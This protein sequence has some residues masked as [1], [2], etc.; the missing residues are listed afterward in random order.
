[1]RGRRL[2]TAQGGHGR[3]RETVA[4]AHGRRLAMM[5]GLLAWLVAF[6]AWSS[7][8]HADAVRN[9][10]APREGLERAAGDLAG[11]I[12]VSAAE[13]GT[14]RVLRELTD[15]LREI[16]AMPSMDGDMP[17]DEPAAMPREERVVRIGVLAFRGNQRA[18]HRWQPLADYLSARVPGVTFTLQ[19]VTLFSARGLLETGR[20]DYLI[21]N[22]GHYVALTRDVPL[23][24][25]A[26]LER[27]IDGGRQGLTR[28]GSVILVRADSDIKTLADLRGR[29]LT[30]VSPLAFGGFQMA[31]AEFAAQEMDP[32]ADLA[33]VRFAGFPQD[34]IVMAVL[35]GE[36]DAGIVRTG[37]IE[38][39][40][41]EGRIRLADVRVLQ[42]D[43][44]PA[45]PHQVSTR[46]Y[47]EWPFLA[48]EGANKRIT[49]AVAR[50]LL[51]TQ[52]P[53]VRA[54][55]GL[56][57]AWTTPSAYEDVR[58]LVTDFEAWR[59]GTLAPAWLSGLMAGVPFTLG[60]LLIVTL[61]VAYTL[62][63][64]R[65]QPGMPSARRSENAAAAVARA[66]GN[67]ATLP[68]ELADARPEAFA[69]LTR[70]EQEVLALLC[71]GLSTKAIARALDISPKTVEYH[72]TNLMK[73][74]GVKSATSLVWLA[75]REGYDRPAAQP[76][77][78]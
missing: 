11:N 62:H 39:M 76:R 55:Y 1:M 44:Y 24:P 2:A 36:T 5:A 22:P 54:S 23:A 13:L 31:W 14:D 46:L 56:R 51:E 10:T 32:F 18:R 48:R 19:P 69:R 74:V 57:H 17:R 12:H 37:L 60:V 64:Q 33:V 73:K 67:P 16:G 43:R 72:R 50:A 52:D 21:T 59:Q 38:S 45:W 20:I 4:R 65:R 30:A 35:R 27:L 40:A 78:A 28:F 49:E 70:R 9:E 26:T 47:P 34:A 25:L 63:Q 6:F 66:G 77:P 58:Q 71:Q 41:R 42:A 29:T 15:I 7:A 53:A 8:A 61:L 75:T 3:K 68:A